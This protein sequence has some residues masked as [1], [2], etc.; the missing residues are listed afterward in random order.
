[1]K[2]LF[3][4]SLL[5]FVFL[6]KTYFSQ[7]ITLYQRSIVDPFIFYMNNTYQEGYNIS[8]G[9]GYHALFHSMKLNMLNNFTFTPVFSY[10]T[11]DECSSI[12][13]R[14]HFRDFKGM[15]TIEALE[16]AGMINIDSYDCLI[17]EFK[18]YL[19]SRKPFVG[20]LGLSHVIEREEYSLIHQLKRKNQINENAFGFINHN[21][22]YKF[23]LGSIP[24]QYN[25]FT[26][27]GECQVNPISTNWMC[28]YNEIIFN[29]LHFVPSV[30]FLVVF[31]SGQ[32]EIFVT[33]ELWQFIMN[34]F[35]SFIKKK[36]CNHI[37]IDNCNVIQCKKGIDK[38]LKEFVL[39]IGE[40][41][42]R[43]PSYKLF[44]VINSDGSVE[45]N[46]KYKEDYSTSLTLGTSFLS[47]YNVV[48]FSYDEGTAKFLTNDRNMIMTVDK[49]NVLKE[50]NYYVIKII[51]NFISLGLI[52]ITLFNYYVLKTKK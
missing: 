50:K 39:M 28:L 48:S 17:S 1:M 51:Y 34:V 18:F 6:I 40:F 5:T 31:N 38:K 14:E 41:V 19:G 30:T 21:N 8:M 44:K 32:H 47:L 52:V 15:C 49:W 2:S 13:Q 20:C 7:K 45:L 36:L 37:Q 33:K 12:V 3:M 43:I 35:E 24:P 23:Y 29:D 9:F 22:E 27:K 46:L 4:F 26:N 10:D 25:T 11:Q 42:Y 16:C